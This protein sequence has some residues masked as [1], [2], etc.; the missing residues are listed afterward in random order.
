MVAMALQN[1]GAIGRSAS[2]ILYLRRIA[3]QRQ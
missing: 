2:L 3:R 1:C